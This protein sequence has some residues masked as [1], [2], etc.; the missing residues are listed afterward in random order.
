MLDILPTVK[1]FSNLDLNTG[2]PH[3][4]PFFY[5]TQRARDA[6]NVIQLGNGVAILKNEGAVQI[7]NQKVPIGDFISVG[8]NQQGKLLQQKQVITPMSRISVIHLES[9]GRYIVLDSEYLNSTYIQMYVF[10]NYDH[11][12]FEPVILTPETKIY[13]VKI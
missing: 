11:E 7:G 1:I 2:S 3:S 4:R 13:R 12:L 8:Y 5:A 10:E 6:G 9:L